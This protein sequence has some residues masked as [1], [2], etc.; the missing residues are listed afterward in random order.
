[1]CCVALR[2]VENDHVWIMG[3]YGRI[4]GVAIACDGEMSFS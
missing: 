4:G 1:M 2:Q 3:A